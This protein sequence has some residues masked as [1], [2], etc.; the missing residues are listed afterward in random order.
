MKRIAMLIFAVTVCIL[1]PSLVCCSSGAGALDEYKQMLES[2][3]DESG[4]AANETFADKVYLIISENCSGELSLSAKSLA[5]AIKE[6][7]KV[8]TVL[9]YDNESISLGQ[10]D[11]VILLGATNYLSSQ[12]AIK[13]L[14]YDDYVC[15]WDGDAIVLGGRHDEATVKAIERFTSEVLH[16]ASSACLMN[17]NSGFAK[18]TKYKFS[19]VTLNGF[20]LYDYTFVYPEDNAGGEKEYIEILRNYIVKK[21]G[22]YLNVITDKELDGTVGKIISFERNSKM[23]GASVTLDGKS[24]Y[25]KASDGYEFSVITADIAQKLFSGIQGAID[26]EISSYVRSCE[27]RTINVCRAFSVCDTAY[28]FDFVT[29][30]A[31]MI[32]DSDHDVIIFD[33]AEAWFL[34]YVDAEKGDYNLLNATD[35][36]G[37]VYSV[38]YRDGLFESVKAE[39]SKLALTVKLKCVGEDE[40]RRVVCPLTSD[41]QELDELL[42]T[43]T[44]YDVF[45]FCGEIPAKLLDYKMTVTDEKTCSLY[46]EERK[47][48]L[49]VKDA[50]E[51]E[52]GELLLREGE[53]TNYTNT[54]LSFSCKSL[55]CD[56][57]GKLKNSLK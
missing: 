25:V 17:K 31:A 18:M 46:G 38:L 20:D 48:L 44:D 47:M 40:E 6:K 22:Y 12:E 32:Q 27:G 8:D 35:S 7:T 56:S 19:D 28:D 57:F 42:E 33:K 11:L 30:W 41:A 10:R 51:I 52:N 45:L 53:G 37:N 5:D 54:F 23:S 15:Q 3:S 29:E 49:A 13:P 55:F 24:L 50:F 4:E 2:M 16:G 39:I 36:S 43:S 26:A 1:L 34:E 9:K 21:S 14:R